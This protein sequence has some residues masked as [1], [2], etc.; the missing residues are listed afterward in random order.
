VLEDHQAAR[1]GGIADAALLA[2]PA[3]RRRRHE[4]PA[5][6]EQPVQDVHVGGLVFLEPEHEGHLPRRHAHIVARASSRR[7][8]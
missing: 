4:A 1:L 8:G 2:G 3:E 7:Q 6:G 5:V